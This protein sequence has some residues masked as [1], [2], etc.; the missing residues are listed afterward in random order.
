MGGE[1][2][3]R[4]DSRAKLRNTLEANVYRRNDIGKPLRFQYPFFASNLAWTVD[5]IISKEVQYGLYEAH[6]H[7][8]NMRFQLQAKST[9][10][11]CEDICLHVLQKKNYTVD[12]QCLCLLSNDEFIVQSVG[13]ATMT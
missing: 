5:G 10:G 4:A 7:N 2:V 1:I 13:L 8:L 6:I 12:L 9:R 3:T 11:Y